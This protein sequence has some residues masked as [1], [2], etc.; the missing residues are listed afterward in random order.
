MVPQGV[1]AGANVQVALAE[2]GIVCKNPR[3]VAKID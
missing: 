2:D 3:Q 1:N